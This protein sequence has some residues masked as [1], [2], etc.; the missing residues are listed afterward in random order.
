MV[1]RLK[2]QA[3]LN[4]VPLELCEWG[5]IA[6]ALQKGVDGLS[7]GSRT[8][9]RKKEK[10]EFYSHALA[11]FRNFKDAWRNNVSHTRTTYNPA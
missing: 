3:H 11:V 7:S 8:D 6:G 2:V 9:K 10:H 4:G 5:V 1:K